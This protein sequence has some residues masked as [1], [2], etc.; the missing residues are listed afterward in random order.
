[1]EIC[2]LK[3]FNR[4]KKFSPEDVKSMENKINSPGEVTLTKREYQA[5]LSNRRYA[6]M[7]I[8]KPLS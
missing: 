4:F 7:F 3:I 2:M 1:M 8:Y 6:Y 5:F